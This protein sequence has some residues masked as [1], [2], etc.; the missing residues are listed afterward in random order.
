M[1]YML[2]YTVRH[3]L[4]YAQNLEN[5]EALTLAFSKWKPENGLTVHA[6]VSNL[7]G[8]KGYALVET[9]DPK[10]ITSFLSKFTYWNDIEAIPVVD[11][12]EAVSVSA[13]SRGW[14]RQAVKA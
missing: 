9:Q 1:K 10:T 13:E 3:G 14:T 11:V 5:S 2:E 12:G 8:D 4:H 6:F 7:V